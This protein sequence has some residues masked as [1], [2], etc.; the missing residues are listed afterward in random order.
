[1]TDS[2]IGGGYR[3][4]ENFFAVDSTSLALLNLAKVPVKLSVH[5][6]TVRCPGG[7][8]EN[9]EA[10]VVYGY[11][12]RVRLEPIPDKDSRTLTIYKSCKYVHPGGRPSGFYEGGI[13]EIV[14]VN[15]VWRIVRAI[16][17]VIT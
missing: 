8:D 4:N 13:W 6:Q 7:I 5:G 2:L 15:G 11:W 12:V 14:R 9:A 10:Q 16:D 3:E 1:V 17:R